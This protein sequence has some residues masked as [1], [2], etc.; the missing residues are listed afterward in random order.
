MPPGT[1]ET[2]STSILHF[3]SKFM[4]FF[5]KLHSK[6]LFSDEW[7]L[8]DLQEDPDEMKNVY[9]DPAYSEIVKSM[10]ARLEKERIEVGDT[11]ELTATSK[12]H[13]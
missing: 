2:I 11:V 13:R 12:Y 9:T 7:E 6:I 4:T 1:I 3:L 5:V 8:F 10:T